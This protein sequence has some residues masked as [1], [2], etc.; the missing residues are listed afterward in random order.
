MEKKP[1][2][3]EVSN[4]FQ[5]ALDT[6]EALA[7][8]TVSSMKELSMHLGRMDEDVLLAVFSNA[9]LLAILAEETLRIRRT[10]R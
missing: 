5:E 1:D 4:E 8:A 2:P 6:L 9:H 10:K 7:D 3:I